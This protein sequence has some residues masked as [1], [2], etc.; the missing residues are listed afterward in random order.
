L[1]KGLLLPI[2]FIFRYSIWIDI[3]MEHPPYFYLKEKKKLAKES[4]KV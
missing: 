3:G 4:V 1:K 2:L